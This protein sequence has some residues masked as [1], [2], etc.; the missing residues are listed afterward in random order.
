MLPLRLSL[1][2]RADVGA[3]TALGVSKAQGSREPSWA[4]AGRTV[5]GRLSGPRGWI[6]TEMRRE[7][8]VRKY[9]QLRAVQSSETSSRG[10]RDIR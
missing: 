7:G 1:E 4:K 3:H 2:Y 10:G 8:E 9:S 6:W 5:A